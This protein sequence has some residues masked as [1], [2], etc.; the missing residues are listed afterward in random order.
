MPAGQ[1]IITAESV[2][3]YNNI[4]D[5]MQARHRGSGNNNNVVY[6]HRPIESAT[7]KPV[8]AQ[9]EWIPFAE[10]NKNLDLKSLFDQANK[11]IDSIY[12]VPA[13]VRG[14]NDNNTYASVRVDEQIFIKYTIKPFATRIWSEFTHQL[15]R[16]TGGLGFAITFDLDI[17]GVAEEEKIEAERKA[18]ELTLIKTGLDMGYS[19]DSIVDAFELSNGYKTLKM[20][21]TPPKIENDKPEVDDGGEVEE[22]PEDLNAKSVHIHDD[23]E[24]DHCLKAETKT[25]NEKQKDKDQRALEAVFRDMTNEQIE[26]AIDSDFEDFNLGDKD[27]EKFKQRI[28]VILLSV[29][30]TRGVVAWSD[31]TSILKQNNISTDELTEFKISDKL[32]KHYDKMITDFTKSFSEDTARSIVNRVAQAETEDWNK[33][34]LARSLRDITKAEEWRIQRIARTETHRAHGLAGVEAGVQIQN[35]SGVQ[36]YKEWVVV[37]ANPCK[38]CRGMDGRRVNVT[39]SYVKKGG[40][41]IGKSKIRVNDYADIDTAGAHPNCS[42]VE[43]FG[44]EEEK[45]KIF[46]YSKLNQDDPEYMYPHEQDFYERLVKN[47]NNVERVPKHKTEPSNDFTVNGEAWELKSILG[48]VK[49]MTIRNEIY[50]ATDKGKRNIFLDVYNQDIDV[51]D[52]VE[53]AKKHISIKKNNDKID[54]LIVVSGDKFHKIK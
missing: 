52:V 14:V 7:G 39:E 10:S 40:I 11:K 32:K 16:I 17:P 43:K 21:E 23:C 42:C 50:H 31:F 8:N 12:G 48:K 38:Y 35:E 54:S 53:K 34:E 47:F 3:E 41:L 4:V 44:I 46:D 27:R 24:D 28:K 6:I 15:N 30:V 49:P 22:S 25:K 36:I 29:L 51:N 18:A 1:F 13:S 33:E 26:R 37:S 5:N 19:L 9:I 2:E 45:D 20:G